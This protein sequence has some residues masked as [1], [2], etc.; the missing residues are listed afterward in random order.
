[1]GKKLISNEFFNSF[2]LRTACPIILAMV[3]IV[4]G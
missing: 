1:M 2:A 4:V 3:N